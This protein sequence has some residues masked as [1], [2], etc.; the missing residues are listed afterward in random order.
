MPMKVSIKR[1][2]VAGVVVCI[3]SKDR[4]L[5][6]R[7][8]NADERVGQWTIPGGKVDKSDASYI[9]GAQRELREET[10][11]STRPSDLQYIGMPKPEKYYYLA[12]E[13]E[14]EVKI[15]I[16]NPKTGVIEHDSYKWATI[17]EIKGLDNTEI[18][19]YLLEEALEI[20]KEYKK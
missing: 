15:D 19:I 9:A 6:L 8:S 5:L 20:F 14:G 12:L 18:P 17:K 11:L 10:G 16:P 1:P 3:D 2:L 13:W 7:R 4:F